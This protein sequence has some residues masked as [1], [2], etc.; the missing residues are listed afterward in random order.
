MLNTAHRSD[1]DRLASLMDGQ[2][3]RLLQTHFSQFA[4]TD[5][6]SPPI[7]AYRRAEQIEVC[8]DLAGVEKDTI[9]IRVEPGRLTLRGVRH[10][11]QPECPPG[12]SI[13]ILA[14]EINHG[15]FSRTFNLP[16]EIDSNHITAEQNNGLLWIRMPIITEQS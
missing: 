12:E 8:V 16:Q 6:W 15:P 11:P 13:Q 4:E 5:A 3:D 1:I 7:N 10:A 9:D 2:L 14:M